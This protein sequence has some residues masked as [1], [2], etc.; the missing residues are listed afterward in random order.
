MPNQPKMIET[1]CHQCE[2]KFSAPRSSIKKGLYKYCSRDCR[3][4]SSRI[5]VSCSYCSTEIRTTPSNLKKSKNG[6]HFCDNDC[7]F[8]AAASPKTKYQTGIAPKKTTKNSYRRHMLRESK[9][10]KCVRCG[11]REHAKLLDVDHIDSNRNN[12]AV[13]NLQFLCVM[14]HATKTRLPNLY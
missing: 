8:A 2:C 7:K 14:C 5:T 3:Y 1:I 10:P 12:N 13:S 11:Y 9:D 6:F 4:E